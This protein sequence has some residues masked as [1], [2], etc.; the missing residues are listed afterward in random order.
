[1]GWVG[2][3]VG[4]CPVCRGPSRFLEASFWSLEHEGK[5]VVDAID[6]AIAWRES[7]GLDRLSA[8]DVSDHGANG[9]ILVKGYDLER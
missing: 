7:A 1:M 8:V 9:A 3:S 4:L 2:H 5:R 6:E